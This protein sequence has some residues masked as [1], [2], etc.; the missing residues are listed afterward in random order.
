MVDGGWTK[1]AAKLKKER[2]IS[3]QPDTPCVLCRCRLQQQQHRGLG[4]PAGAKSA[5]LIFLFPGSTTSLPDE[6]F[7]PGQQQIIT[8][9]RSVPMPA[10]GMIVL[11]SAFDYC[12]QPLLKVIYL[13]VH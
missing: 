1:P 11:F 6:T 4:K 13:A 8:A 7:R 3:D 9:T 12:G 2:K 5:R 10:G